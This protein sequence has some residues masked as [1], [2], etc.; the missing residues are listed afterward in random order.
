MENRHTITPEGWTHEQDNSKVLR[1]DGE[2]RA[3]LVREFGFNNYIATE[4]TDFSPVYEY[5]AD[6]EQYWAEVR[7]AWQQRFDQGGVI[8]ETDVDGMPI[9]EGLFELADQLRAD[10]PPTDREIEAVFET[11][12]RPISARMAERSE[13]P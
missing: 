7:R 11:W 13:T 10:D 2:T 5:W 4:D 9:I 3:V 6:T 1:I 12:V 8:L